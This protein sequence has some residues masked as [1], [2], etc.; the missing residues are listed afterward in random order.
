MV[1]PTDPHA[2]LAARV[3]MLEEANAALVR[4]VADLEAT[5][6]A[7]E[8]RLAD[9]EELHVSALQEIRS[10]R[11]QAAREADGSAAA[12]AVRNKERQDAIAYLKHHETSVRFPLG[13]LR[14]VLKVARAVMDSDAAPVR[15][16]LPGLEQSIER[17]RTLMKRES[18]PEGQQRLRG[19]HPLQGEDLLADAHAALA[20][21][22]RRF[23]EQEQMRRRRLESG[24]AR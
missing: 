3:A 15:R 6:V 9:L 7:L 4:R 10:A 22:N 13:A 17:V 11:E 21:Y 19:Q 14:D 23:A 16:V 24:A 2:A 20:E 18:W 8:R 5:N 1:Q 12:E